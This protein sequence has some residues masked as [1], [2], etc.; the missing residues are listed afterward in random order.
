MNEKST[1]STGFDQ[2]LTKA[3]RPGAAPEDLRRN[4]LR[5]AQ[6]HGPRRTWHALGIAATLMFLLG[7]GAWGWMAH[8][9]SQ[10]GQRFTQ[11]FSIRRR[12]PPSPGQMNSPR[13]FGMLWR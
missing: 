12:L 9:N 11:P 10:E 8:W 6:G 2:Q 4:L 3:L 5:A 7:S 1:G 13:I